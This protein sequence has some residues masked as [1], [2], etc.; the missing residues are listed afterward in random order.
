MKFKDFIGGERDV[1]VVITVDEY[2]R[3][4]HI[5]KELYTEKEIAQIDDYC[6]Y[7]W[8]NNRFLLCPPGHRPVMMYENAVTFIGRLSFRMIEFE[9][10]EVKAADGKVVCI[11]TNACKKGVCPVCGN[12]V[13][14]TGAQVNFLP[15]KCPQCGSKGKEGR[16]WLDGNSVFNGVHYDVTD[17]A[18][19]VV[20]SRLAKIHVAQEEKKE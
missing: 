17:K 8:G 7:K 2:R 18:G 6:E 5:F 11:S 1:A 14:Y 16:I 20:V 15:W 4:R 9:D 10:G 19:H 13:D 3:Y 12:T